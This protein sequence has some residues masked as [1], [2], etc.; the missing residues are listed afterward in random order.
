MKKRTWCYIMGPPEYDI[1]CDICGGSNLTWSEFEG[2]VWCYDCQK[3][4]PGTKGVLDGAVSIQGL[5]IFGVSLDRIDLN[6][7]K[8]LRIKE[9][10]GQITWV[11]D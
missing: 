1:F 3:D 11:S 5:L 4:T 8:R 10:N 7:K 6:T 2:Y 9:V